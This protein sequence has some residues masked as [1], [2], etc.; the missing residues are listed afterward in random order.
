VVASAS[1]AEGLGENE[2]AVVYEVPEGSPLEPQAPDDQGSCPEDPPAD[3]A[4]IQYSAEA[5]QLPAI[6]RALADRLDRVRERGYWTAAELVD[7]RKKLDAQGQDLSASR[8]QLQSMAERQC[9]P[10][11]V[12]QLKDEGPLPV[13]DAAEE[14]YSGE[15]VAAIDRGSEGLSAGIW[16]LIGICVIGP[17]AAI[18]WASVKRGVD[19]R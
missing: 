1:A 10:E 8:V 18:I 3:S 17:V 5:R 11:C 4:E 14:Q 15:I 2:P 16:F 19:G 6:C 7:V 9:E 13:E 12:V